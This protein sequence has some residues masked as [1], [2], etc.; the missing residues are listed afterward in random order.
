MSSDILIKRS[1]AAEIGLV[2]QKLPE[3]AQKHGFGVLGMHDLKQ[4]ITAKG[5]EFG[6]ECRVFEVCSPALAR[7][8][9][10]HSL[11]ISAALPCRISV[12]QES[13]RTVLA[14]IK[15][16]LLLTMFATPAAAPLAA[17]V[18]ATLIKIMDEAAGHS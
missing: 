9:L 4:R 7:Q 3:I 17:E 14:T 8:A 15:P 11:E 12:Y 13:G 5:L 16:S 18:E 6:P 10:G 2:S 1:T